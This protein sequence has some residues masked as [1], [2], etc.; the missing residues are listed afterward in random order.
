V[1]TVF[2]TIIPSIDCCF[3]G[4]IVTTSNKHLYDAVCSLVGRADLLLMWSQ[5]VSGGSQET[6][7]GAVELQT[8]LITLLKVLTCTFICN[9]Q[10]NNCRSAFMLFYVTY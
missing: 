2:S 6:A 5:Q 8:R 1:V 10:F 9:E 4:Q 7:A 3:S